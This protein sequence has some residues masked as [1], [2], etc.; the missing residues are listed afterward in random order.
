MTKRWSQRPERSTWGDWGDDDELGRIN[1]ITPEKVLQGVAE[2]QAGVS[3]CLSLPLDFPGGTVLNQRRRPPRLAPTEDL[4]GNPETFFNIHMSDMD[5]RYV[6]MWA[7]DDVTLS[8]QYSTQWDALAHAGA[9]FD[10]DGDGVETAGVL[11]R[12]PG[13]RGHRRP[14]PRRRRRRLRSRQL[15][16]APRPRTHG[17]PRRAGPGRARSTSPTTWAT[18]GG[19]ST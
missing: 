10:V 2:V 17:V 6:D 15:R 1:L 12:L 16:Q 11:Q 8:L 7:D 19:A 4:D 3:F 18:S 9:E 5:P 13:P 14:A